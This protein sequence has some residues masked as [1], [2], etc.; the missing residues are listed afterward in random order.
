MLQVAVRQV[1]VRQVTVTVRQLNGRQVT[2][3]V[4]QV[5]VRQDSILVNIPHTIVVILGGMWR[6]VLSLVDKL[7]GK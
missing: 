5:T 4:R 6:S 3:T 2:V 7:M 1:T